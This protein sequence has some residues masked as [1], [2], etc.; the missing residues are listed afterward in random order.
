MSTIKS[1]K[2]IHALVH[3][4]RNRGEPLDAISFLVS[5]F[6]FLGLRFAFMGP[7]Q[8]ILCGTRILAKAGFYHPA[9]EW[10]NSTKKK[11]SA[12]INADIGMVRIQAHTTD[13][14]TPQR[15]AESLRVAPTPMM[16]PVIV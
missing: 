15:T 11:T 10:Q 12:A 3:K 13:R 4:Y 1:W 7:D 9:S 8:G 6:A 16:A 2:D 14:A 5:R